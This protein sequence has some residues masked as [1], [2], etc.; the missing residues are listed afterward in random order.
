MQNEIDQPEEADPTHIA[1]L[2]KDLNSKHQAEKNVLQNDIQTYKR[3]VRLLLAKYKQLMKQYTKSDLKL[4]L[5][6]KLQDY[7]KTLKD[8]VADLS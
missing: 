7:N 2:V 1:E 3:V 5:S 6:K 4:K 8:T